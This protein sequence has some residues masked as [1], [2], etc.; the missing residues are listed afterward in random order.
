MNANFLMRGLISFWP[1]WRSYLKLKGTDTVIWGKKIYHNSILLWGLRLKKKINTFMPISIFGNMLKLFSGKDHVIGW[2][3]PTLDKPL[4]NSPSRTIPFH[5]N[6]HNTATNWHW[7]FSW[8]ARLVWVI[9]WNMGDTLLKALAMHQPSCQ[10]T[11]RQNFTSSFS[12]S[13]K[14]EMLFQYL[15]DILYMYIQY[16]GGKNAEARV[17]TAACCH[18]TIEYTGECCISSSKYSTSLLCVNIS[19]MQPWANQNFSLSSSLLSP[20]TL[21]V[22]LTYASQND[23]WVSAPAGACYTLPLLLS[24]SH[25]HK[26][27]RTHMATQ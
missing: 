8:S 12:I 17:T 1:H 24:N 9:Q 7:W 11:K 6:W 15:S 20:P 18:K 4:R 21:S 25:S 13:Y 27:T 5:G 14:L 26:N 16:I 10:R 19:A 23:Q 3:G 22:L 2:Y